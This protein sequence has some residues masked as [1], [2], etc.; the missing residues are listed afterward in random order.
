MPGSVNPAQPRSIAVINR[1]FWPLSGSAELE[2]GN[3]C[4]SLTDSGHDVDILT[5]RWQ[6]HWPAQFRFDRCDVYRLSKLS[7]GPFG[8][9]RYLKSLSAHFAQHCYDTAIVFGIGEEANTVAT[10]GDSHLNLILRITQLHLTDIHQFSARQTDAIKSA[11]AILADTQ[12]TADFISRHLPQAKHRIDIVPAFA[13]LPQ[14]QGHPEPQPTDRAGRRAAARVALSDA[15]PILQ[16][17]PDHPLVITAASMDHDLGVCDLVQAWKNVQRTHTH[18][19]LWILGEGRL[20]K[21][22]WDEILEL[23]L[24]YTAIMPGFF[25]NLR[26]VLDAAD[27]YVHPL[28]SPSSCSVLETAKS[29]GLCTVQTA[30]LD[31]LKSAATTKSSRP[32]VTSPQRGLLIPR[33]TPAAIAAT[34]NYLIEHQDFTR[35]SAQEVQRQFLNQTALLPK[36]IDQWLAPPHPVATS[37]TP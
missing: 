21:T 5:V 32:F 37:Q 12:G 33:E 1:K 31:E 34:I 23:D 16:I 17:Q 27:L 7:N 30:S 2:V 18:S 26:L 13:G 15:H 35:Q 9:F 20:S 6:K 10:A 25:D 8:S 36:R 24:V 28:R 22:V 14:E 4:R 3:L 29:A 11:T 19:R